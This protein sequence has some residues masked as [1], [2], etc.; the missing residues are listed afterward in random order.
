[1]PKFHDEFFRSGSSKHDE[2]V[3]KIILGKEKII[4]EIWLQ[5]IFYDK[6]D[7]LDRDIYVCRAN[8]KPEW[9]TLDHDIAHASTPYCNFSYDYRC[10]YCDTNKYQSDKIKFETI[11]CKSIQTDNILKIDTEAEK[12]CK[13][14]NFIIGYIDVMYTV[15]I[16]RFWEVKISDDWGWDKFGKDAPTIKIVFDAKPE[17]KDWGGPLRQIKTY[18]DSESADYGVIVT[19]SKVSDEYQEI[20]AQENV[21]IVTLEN[22]SE[23]K[24]VDLTNF[25]D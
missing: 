17:L 14:G 25:G 2:L 3:S 22:Q 18:M 12:I 6:F 1:M 7:N 23:N 8:N 16:E 15:Q 19:Y 5:R 11:K 4:G 21:F 13:N 24:K 10:K 9:C 20:L